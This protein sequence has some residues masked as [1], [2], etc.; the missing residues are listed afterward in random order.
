MHDLVLVDVGSLNKT[1]HTDDSSTIE[2]IDTL[3]S[4]DGQSDPVQSAERTAAKARFREAFAALP[5]R[6]RLVAVLLYVEGSTLSRHR[7]A[8]GR[9]REPRLPDPHRASPQTA[10]D[11]G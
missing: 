1:I 7:R 9:L 2:R 10:P 5:P 3:E 11:A 8:P 6:E 4:A